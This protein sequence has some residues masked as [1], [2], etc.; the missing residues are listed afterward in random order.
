ML[1]YEYHY[2]LTPIPSASH[3]IHPAF[4]NDPELADIMNVNESVTSL[5][6]P[7]RDPLRT[8]SK[9]LFSTVASEVITLWLK[10][11][12]ITRRY[13]AVCRAGW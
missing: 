3:N 13:G 8:A 10:P 1:D 12:G 4:R 7:P 5:V 11:V 9:P 6:P 2:P